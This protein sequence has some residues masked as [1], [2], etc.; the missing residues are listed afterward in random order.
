MNL[1]EQYFLCFVLWKKIFIF[2]S[3]DCKKSYKV[4]ANHWLIN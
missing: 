4:A 3:L 2:V 1:I